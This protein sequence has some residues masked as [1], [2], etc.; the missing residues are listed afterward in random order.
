[1]TVTQAGAT[2]TTLNN[3]I[4][5]V[6]AGGANSSM[7]WNLQSGAVN[8]GPTTLGANA[9]GVGS[10][11]QTGGT[12]LIGAGAGGA[13]NQFVNFNVG[14]TGTG[15]Y[16]ISGG[17]IDTV[18][19]ISTPDGNMTL[20]YGWGSGMLVGNSTGQGTLKIIGSNSTVKFASYWGGGTETFFMLGANGTLIYEINSPTVTPI[21]IEGRD[22]AAGQNKQASLAGIIDLDLNSYAPGFL[23]TYDLLTARTILDSG[24]TLAPED[25]GFW[26][27][28]I[29]G[30]AGSGQ[31]LR[32]T[33]LPEPASISL[34]ALG[35]LALLRRRR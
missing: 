11:I 27:L 7:T 17:T 29:V 14:G 18:G 26:A 12:M 15:F 8:F 34:L 21:Q 4:F 2:V 22:G 25:V 16:S 33:F 13:G 31:T 20:G 30:T 19:Q 24:Y 35:G 5:T 23:S 3:G 10:I 28:S 32:A 1:M 6:F 9:T